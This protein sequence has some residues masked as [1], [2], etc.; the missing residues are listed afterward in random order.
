[1]NVH[2][3]QANKTYL[4]FSWDPQFPLCPSL[5]YRIH[6]KHCGSCPSSVDST[7]FMC[8]NVGVTTDIRAC[9]VAVQ[10]RCA[11]MVGNLSDI[12]QVMLKGDNART[13]IFY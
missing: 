12:F 6:T 3:E 13:L 8:K 7:T 1:M 10:A 4:T 5:R 2:L 11:D 9:S